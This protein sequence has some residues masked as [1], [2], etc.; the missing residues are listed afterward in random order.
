VSH[1]RVI[2]QTT[3]TSSNSGVLTVFPELTKNLKYSVKA[4]KTN[5]QCNQTTKA[6]EGWF[7][8]PTSAVVAC[9]AGKITL[10]CNNDLS[11]AS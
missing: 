8:N 4:C 11:A 1:K 10:K 2:A 9:T 5:G 7:K 6:C 3:V